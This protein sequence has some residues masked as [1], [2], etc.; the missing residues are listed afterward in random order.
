M[1]TII[2]FPKKENEENAFYYSFNINYENYLLICF[3]N[4]NEVSYARAEFTDDGGF[5]PITIPIEEV[6][7]LFDKTY[8]TFFLNIT[9]EEEHVQDE[10]YVALLFFDFEDKEY[11]LYYHEEIEDLPLLLFEI[12]NKKVKKIDNPFMI[13]RIIQFI[14]EKFDIEWV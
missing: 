8:E 11:A 13:K 4:K 12:E 7:Q 5:I 6:Q 14:D 9:N 10:R 1:G 3:E 2:P